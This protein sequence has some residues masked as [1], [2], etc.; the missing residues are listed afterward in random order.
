M[1]QPIFVTWQGISQAQ[2]GDPG[3]ARG[4]RGKPHAEDVHKTPKLALE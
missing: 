1:R 2:S 4:E 3:R